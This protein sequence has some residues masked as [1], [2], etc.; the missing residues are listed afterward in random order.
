MIDFRDWYRSHA[1][2]R[3]TVDDMANALGV[4][5]PTATR[6]I[7]EGLTADDIVTLS[8]HLDVNPVIA[9]VDLGKLTHAEVFAFL[10]GDGTLLAAAS[11]EQL[12]YQLAEEALPASDRIALGA[13]AKA[14]ID[15]RDDL[16]ARRGTQ[17]ADPL[18]A[19]EHEYNPETGEYEPVRS[20]DSEDLVQGERYV[21][22]TGEPEPEMGD[23]DYH[24]GP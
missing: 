20:N 19:S 24:D 4:S 7:K 5:R 13:A 22:K 23:D 1:D 2:G 11:P 8:R 12:I 14:L 16:A 9:L 10:D 17:H 21:A 6:R 15:R 3:I 18:I